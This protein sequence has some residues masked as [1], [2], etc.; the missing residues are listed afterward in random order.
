LLI[1]DLNPGI[2]G[3]DGHDHASPLTDVTRQMRIVRLG[4]GVDRTGRLAE[5]ALARTMSALRAYAGLIASAKPEAVRMGA[6]GAITEP[7]RTLRSSRTVCSVSAASRRRSLPA[8]KRPG[9][10]SAGRRGNWQAYRSPPRAHVRRL[11]S[12]PTSAA[13]PPSSCWAEPTGSQARAR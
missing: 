2:P 1:A 3:D 7:P 11:T 13:A 8:T 4:E 9:C 5:A 12:L 10:R 6:P